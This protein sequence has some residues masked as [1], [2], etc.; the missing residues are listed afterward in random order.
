VVNTATATPTSPQEP[1]FAFGEGLSYTTVDYSNLRLA[2]DE[3]GREGR[4]NATIT[5]T[6]TGPRTAT[7]TVQAYV[8][9]T[10]T[11]VTWADRE[12]KGFAQVTVQPGESVDV[13]IAIAAA[14]CS[15]VTA[16]GHRVVEPGT[17]ELLVGK[18]SR[19]GDLLRAVFTI[20]A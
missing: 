18:S 16:A 10:V 11:S 1:L 3:I 14:D 6:N 5:L 8:S 7:E 17:F 13:Q 4:I 20:V 15:I 19:S 9:D 2:A 12:L